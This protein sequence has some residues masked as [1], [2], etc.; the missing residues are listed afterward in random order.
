MNEAYN[1]DEMEIKIN[2]LE[3]ELTDSNAIISS[4]KGENERL[5]QTIKTMNKKLDELKQVNHSHFHL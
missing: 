2:T 3:K 5:R 1:L 4:L